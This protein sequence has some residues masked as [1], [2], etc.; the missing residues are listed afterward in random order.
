[1]AKEVTISVTISRL[2]LAGKNNP[3]ANEPLA[4][5]YIMNRLRAKGVPVTGVLTILAVEWGKLTIAHEDG[6]DGDEWTYTWTG[7]PMPPRWIEACKEVQ[8]IPLTN[9]LAPRI[10]AEDEL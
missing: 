9:P 6:L 8:G 3:K 2:E 1:M 10:A 5:M 7:A 4:A